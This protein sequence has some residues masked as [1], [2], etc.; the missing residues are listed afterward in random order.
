M[1]DTS[2]L[3]KRDSQYVEIR[4]RDSAY[5]YTDHT[6]GSRATG[7]GGFAYYP[8]V[9]D[10]SPFVTIKVTGLTGNMIRGSGSRWIL[11]VYSLNGTIVKSK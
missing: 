9:P 6:T 1:C 8:L 11:R 10:W 3:F 7:Y 2:G 5:V 4:R